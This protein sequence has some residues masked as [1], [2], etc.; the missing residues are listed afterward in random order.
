M[1]AHMNSTLDA[2]L[3]EPSVFRIGMLPSARNRPVSVPPKCAIPDAVSV[4]LADEFSQLP[5]IDETGRV[6]GIVTLAGIGSAMALETPC[7]TVEDCK[8]AARIVS[9]TT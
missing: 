2:N 1:P 4:M 8:E 5:I 7:A 3:Q 9:A 6:H